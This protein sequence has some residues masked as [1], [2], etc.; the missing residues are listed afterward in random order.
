MVKIKDFEKSGGRNVPPCPTHLPPKV[1][2]HRKF[3]TFSDTRLRISI[4]HFTVNNC[5]DMLIETSSV[6]VEQR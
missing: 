3:E 4:S 6:R 1:Y 5:Q 2:I